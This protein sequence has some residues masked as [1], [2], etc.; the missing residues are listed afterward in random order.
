MAKTNKKSRSIAHAR[1]ILTM[2]T[3]TQL[4]SNGSLFLLLLLRVRMMTFIY[5]FLY[6]VF[7]QIGLLYIMVIY[8][9]F[10]Q[11]HTHKK[12]LRALYSRVSTS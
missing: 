1:K 4:K 9:D 5:I 6:T 10:F 12:K 2:H 8:G 3:R 7:A 11:T